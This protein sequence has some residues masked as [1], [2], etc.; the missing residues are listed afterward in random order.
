MTAAVSTELRAR[1]IGLVLALGGLMVVIDTVMTAVALPAI[2]TDLDTTVPRGAWMT[3][4]YILGLIVVIPLSGWLTGRFGDRRVYLTGL[5]VFVLASV[6][7]GFSPTV[8]A[9]IVFRVLQGI[10]GG[11]LNPVGTAIALRS[12]PDGQRGRIMS[13]VGLPALI[14]PALAAP[15]TGTLVDVA[16]W[17]WLFWI[18]LPLGIAAV[19]LCLRHLPAAQRGQERTK[20]HGLGLVL[21]TVGC[22]ALVLACT[23]IGDSGHVTAVTAVAG[24][25]GLVLLAWFAR[26]SLRQPSPLVRVRLLARRELAAGAV[27]SSCFAGGYFGASAII[28]AFVQGV[29]GDPVSVA[30]ILAVPAGLTVGAT[31]Q[32]ATRLVD[33]IPARRVIMF[34]TATAL[35]GAVAL[36]VAL[37][38]D[39]PYPA[40]GA[41]SILVGIGSGATLM[42]TTVAATAGLGG[43]ELPQA[44]TLLGLFSQFGTA[45]GTALV[46]STITVLIAAR[47][48]DLDVD[49]QRGLAAIVALDPAERAPLVDHLAG[50]IG[51]SYAVPATLILV[52]LLVA[53]WGLRT[54]AR[55][56]R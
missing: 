14:G 8:A 36:G 1:N 29:R 31:L 40:I 39:A 45:F 9:L 35:A 30:G 50:A 24:L 20:V 4:G 55:P 2:V 28:P 6:A 43:A 54:P 18:N 46:A 10:G 7:A 27:I 11:V 41:V 52:A 37:S 49:G 25:G 19:T 16:S 48:P 5:A 3:T 22:A 33:R 42:P 44:T 51:P 26:R 15:L 23:S 32:V 53:A 38:L 56:A 34:G 12:A 17:R 13:L 21:V 47:F